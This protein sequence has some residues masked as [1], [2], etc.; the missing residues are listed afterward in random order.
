MGEG[1][2]RRTR[3]LWLCYCTEYRESLEGNLTEEPVVDVREPKDRSACGP[4]YMGGLRIVVVCADLGDADPI[5]LSLEQLNTGSL[6]AYS[7]Q[8]ELRLNPPIS[9]VALFVLFDAACLES[10]PDTL[11]WLGRFWPAAA[12]AVVGAVGASKQEVM[13]RMGGAMY[14]THPAYGGQW[15]SLVQLASER[16]GRTDAPAA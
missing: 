2:V 1:L 13:A 16:A 8:S 7:R 10:T 11:Q 5:A 15:R 14:F 9:D 6:L 4:T 12:K 3:R